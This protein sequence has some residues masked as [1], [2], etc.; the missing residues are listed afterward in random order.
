MSTFSYETVALWR[1]GQTAFA[2]GNVL[3][4]LAACVLAVWLGLLVGRAA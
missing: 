2:T 4:T 3:F 1:D